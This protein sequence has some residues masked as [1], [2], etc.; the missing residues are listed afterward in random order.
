MF[1]NLRRDSAK[2]TEIGGWY[3]HPGFWIVAIY[4]LGVWAQSLPSG[5]LRVPMWALYR[6]VKLLTRS[7]NVDLWAGSRGARI[8]AGLCLI[9]PFNILIGRGVEIGEDC[10]I[11]HEVTLGTGPVPGYPKIGNGV[12]VY[13]GARVL[14]GVVIGDHSMI[15][16]N[17]AV[18][19]DVPPRS[20]VVSAPIRIIPRSLSPVA[21]RADQQTRINT[22][23]QPD[24]SPEMARP[25]CAKPSQ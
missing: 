5:F 7:F 10:L 17:C 21:S 13:V 8:G 11:F 2:Y 25:R 14:G 24:A 3:T 12:D 6:L 23:A 22:E 20:V 16:A 18:M 19:R 1:E 4:R 9:H 15:G